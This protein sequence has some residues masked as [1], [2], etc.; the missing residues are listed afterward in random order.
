MKKKGKKQNKISSEQTK[1]KHD[2]NIL[3][4][5]HDFFKSFEKKKEKE[6][7]SK[8]GDDSFLNKDR[9]LKKNKHGLPII[10]KEKSATLKPV[11]EKSDENFVRLLESSFHKG[12]KPGDKKKQFHQNKPSIPI[13][14]RLKRYPPPEIELDLH[15]FTAA[16]AEAKTKSFIENCNSVLTNLSPKSLSSQAYPPI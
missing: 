6:L 8:A 14:R 3:E 16:G 15:G 2:I 12:Q 9:F 1:N 10:E 13:K 11:D 5:G 7:S 4:P